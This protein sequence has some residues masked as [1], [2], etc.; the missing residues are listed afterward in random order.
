MNDRISTTLVM[1]VFM[2]RCCGTEPS[3]DPRLMEL[4]V[5]HGTRII[6]ILLE[7]SHWPSINLLPP[8]HLACRTRCEWTCLRGPRGL[9]DFI[10]KASGV[11]TWMRPSGTLL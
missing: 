2:G 1:A 8:F 5:W 11:S 6:G 3:K 7:E 9:W 4:P 10:M